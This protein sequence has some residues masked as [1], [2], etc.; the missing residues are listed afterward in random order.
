VK[1]T[2][3]LFAGLTLLA[4]SQQGAQADYPLNLM[5]GITKVSNHIYDLHMLILWIC[6]FIGIAVFGTMFY[7]IFHHRKS[8]GHKAAQF[9]ENT[10]VE[11]IWTIIP[12][13]ILVAMAIPATKAVIELDDVQ[14]SEMSI[15]VTGK[16]WYWDYQYLD[17]G[18]KFESHL[19]EASEKAHRLANGN[20]H[21]VPH[22]LLNVDNPLVVPVNKKIRFVFTAADVIHSWWVP[23]L[24]W[25]KDA[26]PGFINEAWTFVPKAGTYRG[27]C[28]ELCG[29]DHGFM[30]I[31]VIAMEQPDY[32][33]WVKKTLAKQQEKVDLSDLTREDLMSKGASVYLKNCVSCHQINGSGITGTYP[34][35]TASPRVIGPIDPLIG[36]IQAGTSRMPAFSK[37]KDD[38]LAALLTYIRNAPELGNSVGDEIQPKTITPVYDDE[39]DDKK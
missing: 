14:D 13:L 16:Q 34:A 36:F 31:V 1:K 7:S 3:Q 39:D 21:S 9:H 4:S 20:P 26:N 17:N 33:A 22:Y 18:I 8:K 35:L 38:E 11:I 15:K 2:K 5:E 24:G 27:Q 32:D 37:L 28:T 29:R 30:P 23:D 12:T 6:V 10:T 25:K 19:D